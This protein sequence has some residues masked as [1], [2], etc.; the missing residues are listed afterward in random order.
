MSKPNA[1]HKALRTCALFR[2]KVEHDRRREVA[3]QR[4][5]ESMRDE[6]EHGVFDFPRDVQEGSA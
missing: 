1:Q 5:I 2:P 4:A 3:E 6:S